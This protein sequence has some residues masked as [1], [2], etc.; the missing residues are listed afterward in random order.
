MSAISPFD[1]AATDKP[2][3]T[4]KYEQVASKSYATVRVAIDIAE[5]IDP[6]TEMVIS[7]F[8][9]ISE[10]ELRLI[11]RATRKGSVVPE[12][13]IIGEPVADKNLCVLTFGVPLRGLGVVVT[14]VE[15]KGKAIKVSDPS[16]DVA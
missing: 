2:V 3:G 4:T 1:L 14:E 5:H 15:V 6:S 7:V 12:I 10:K 11:G 9:K 13:S 16:V 8:E